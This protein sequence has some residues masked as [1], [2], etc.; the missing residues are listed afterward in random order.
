MSQ[1][2]PIGK[3]LKEL[4]FIT[5]EQIEVALEVQKVHR[6]FIGEIL[7][8]LDFITSDE[9]ARA[10]A[11]QSRLEYID[12]DMVV[13]KMEVLKLVPKDFA[14]STPLLPIDLKDDNTIVVAVENPNDLNVYDYIN[15]IT[16]KKVKFVISDKNKIAKYAQLYYYQLEHP[17]EK[18]IEDMIKTAT[19]GKEIDIVK[20][21]DLILHNAVKD[22][23][24]DIHITPEPY[25]TH[26]FY[27][28]DGVLKHCFAVPQRLHSSMVSRIKIVSSLN[29]A[30][31]R[32]PQDGGFSFS[33]LETDYDVRVS[34][35][36]TN[37][38][39]NIVLRLLTKNSS[40]FN[41]QN[42]GFENEY[43]KKIE[44]YFK[45]PY[46]IVLVVGPTG[47][48]KTTTLYSA[49]RKIDSLEKNVLTVEDPIEYR[50]TFIKQ[51]QVNEKAGYTFAKAIKTFMR[52]DPDVMLVGEIRDEE[53]AELA[54]RASITGHLVLSTL[55]TN[56]APSTVSRL[57]DLGLKSYMIAEGLLAIIAQRLV[58][59][60]CENCK[61]KKVYTKDELKKFGF[62]DRLLEKIESEEIVIYEKRGCE[63][64]R[65]TGYIGR[66]A[67]AE[68]ME[69]SKEIKELIVEG[70]STIDIEKKAI[71]EGMRSLREDALLKVL[72]GE[73]SLEEVDRVVG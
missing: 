41:L 6:K 34:T 57:E 58:R 52:Q 35:L 9:I 54:V 29:I 68:L 38:G 61:E 23:A 59:K 10:V 70:K 5:E 24:T 27:R 26:I 36:P 37:H 15:R 14:I 66:L 11:L 1:Q 51:S 20:F 31:Q 18:Y 3:L 44:Y 49:L 47:S 40:L 21:I 22:R 43:V 30:E 62:T 4:G 17:I 55:H 25:T 69:I 39:E 7:Q 65:H 2:K 56:D 42:L 53:T 64:C 28:I 45:K 46:G 33:F 12:L 50:F 72:R 63:H 67:I 32:L 73:T 16:R 71:E 48:G 8:D 13:P 19:E 60:L